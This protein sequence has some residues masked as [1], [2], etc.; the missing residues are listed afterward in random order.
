[1]TV[2]FSLVQDGIYELGKA[3]M[4]L[5]PSLRSF[6]NVAFETVQRIDMSVA[7]PLL[8]TSHT[9]TLAVQ[10]RFQKGVA[11]SHDGN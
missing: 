4:R 2:Q 6:P 9:F 5:T 10:N 8:Y 1:M 11:T 3:H 7:V